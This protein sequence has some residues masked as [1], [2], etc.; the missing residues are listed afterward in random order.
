M[1]LAEFLFLQVEALR[2]ARDF[3]LAAPHDNHNV[4]SGVIDINAIFPGLQ[5]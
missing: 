5:Q 2:L 3:R 4:I 1:E